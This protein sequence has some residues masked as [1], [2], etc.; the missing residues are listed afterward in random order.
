MDELR[1]HLTELDKNQPL[2]VSCQ[3]G[4]RSYNAERILKSAGF[5]VKN[6]DGAY[7]IYSKVT[8]ELLENKI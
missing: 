6:L 4:L 5:D 7:G 2:V 1:E 3:S 8:N